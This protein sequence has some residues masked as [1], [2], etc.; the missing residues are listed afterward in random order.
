MNKNETHQFSASPDLS[1]VDKSWTLFLDRD[2][3][4]NEETVGKYI[5]KWPEFIFSEN[6]LDAF[7]IFAEKFGRII[8]VTNQ[9]GVSKGLMTEDDLLDIHKEM[10]K[11]VMLKGRIDRIYYCTD[12]DDSSYYRK[13]NPG[14]AMQ[15]KEDFPEINFSKSIM[16]GNKPSDMKFGRAAG[17]FTIF[18]TSTNPDQAFPH[19]DIDM[20]FPSLFA[21]A[22]AL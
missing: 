6:A 7:S 1:L 12:P 8:I 15:A 11:Q 16:V 17:M 20:V 14:M 10:Q 22:Q 18:I 2:G 19:P 5:L 3:V 13:P 4:I 21:F 9:R